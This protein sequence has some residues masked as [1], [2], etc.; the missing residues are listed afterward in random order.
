[1]SKGTVVV[2]FQVANYRF[3]GV[4]KPTKHEA[5]CQSTRPIIKQKCL[6]YTRKFIMQTV[7]LADVR[8]RVFMKLRV[9]EL[10]KLK[11]E[12]NV[13]G[14]IYHKRQKSLV[15]SINPFRSYIGPRLTVIFQFCSDVGRC[16]TRFLLRLFAR[17][18][19]LSDAFPYVVRTLA[20][21]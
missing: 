3:Q 12:P 11:T 10:A 13:F 9:A 2:Y 4:R 7:L 15:L 20:N 14:F 21:R 5:M 18:R 1:M 19:S 6:V 8:T 16:P 17:C